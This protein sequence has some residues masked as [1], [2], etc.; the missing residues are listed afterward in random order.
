MRKIQ[1]AEGEDEPITAAAIGN[2]RWLHVPCSIRDE[3]LN[4]RH[5]NFPA[6]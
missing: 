5:G 2:A 1:Q 4:E 3:S 6:I